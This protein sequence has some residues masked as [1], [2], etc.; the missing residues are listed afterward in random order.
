MFLLRLL[1]SNF[2]LQNMAS[3]ILSRI[4]PMIEHN[5]AKYAALRKAFYL[6][7]LDQL[8]GDY[9][10]FGVFTGSS[11]V[12]AMRI[13]D[14]LRYLGNTPTRFFGFDSFSGFG[15]ISEH[16]KHPFYLD[17]IFTVDADRVIRNIKSKAKKA[18]VEIVK[19]YFQDTLSG[20][21]AT[22]LG[23]KKARVIFID[24]DLKDPAALV[25]KFVL[26]AIQQGTV[27]VMDDFFSYSGD[28]AKGVKGAFD[29]FCASQP[30]LRW[31]HI[32]DYGFGGVAMMCSSVS[33]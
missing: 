31:R 33:P 29:E 3:L 20:R 23:I 11:F 16:D 26:P 32:C 22:A 21:A 15:E 28:D 5:V 6:T 18:Q 27:L 2:I 9:L 24:C 30:Q 10:E 1:K 14:K 7:A 13:H 12:F 17:S 4:P 25:L 19:G 8:E